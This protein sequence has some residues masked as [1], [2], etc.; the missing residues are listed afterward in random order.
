[1]NEQMPGRIGLDDF[2]KIDIRVG[3]IV[4]FFVHDQVTDG[5]SGVVYRIKSIK[6]GRLMAARLHL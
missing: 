5:G 1:M 3:T 4:A 2:L 6:Y